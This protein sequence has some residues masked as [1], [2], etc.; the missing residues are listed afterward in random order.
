MLLAL[1]LGAVVTARALGLGGRLAALRDWIDGLGPLGPLVYIVLYAAATAVAIPGS[2]MTLAAGVL[3]GSLWGIAI[4]SI[5]ATLGAAGAFLIAR[6]FARD[7]TAAS[8]SKNPRFRRLYDLTE[9]HGA[10]IVAVTRL[11]PLFPFNL[12]NYGFG[13]TKVSFATYVFWSWLCMLP[14]TVLY[15]VG[16]D[17]VARAVA[18]SEIPWGLTGVLAGAL[19]VLVG[20]GYFAR[21][22]L[23]TRER[24]ASATRTTG[25][26]KH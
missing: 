3:F 15:V 2:P 18:R 20:A 19:V 11:V 10:V 24:G 1:V 26:Q 17:A 25:G 23:R 8:L 22:L 16:A 13:L 9:T 12:L 7:A 21:R 5:A 4:V 6:Y 14:G